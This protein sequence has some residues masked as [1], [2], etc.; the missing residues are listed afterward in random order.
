MNKPSRFILLAQA[1]CL[2]AAL[3]ACGAAEEPRPTQAAPAIQWR[4]ETPAPLP[5]PTI[6]AEL[7]DGSERGYTEID[8]DTSD[9]Y[10]DFVFEQ[11]IADG[12]GEATF[13]RLINGEYR[14]LGSLPGY[15]TDSLGTPSVTLDGMGH[16]YLNAPSVHLGWA[17]IDRAYVVE[18][19]ALAE[20]PPLFQLYYPI[21]ETEFTV[22][23]PAPVL[24]LGRPAGELKALM[25]DAFS[26]FDWETIGGEGFGGNMRIDPGE[27]VTVFG[28][29][30]R[31]NVLLEYTHE[32]YLFPMM[33]EEDDPVWGDL[34]ADGR[35][36]NEY[37]YN[38][39]VEDYFHRG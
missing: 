17:R 27:T 6:Q 36:F 11:R 12:Y 37:F 30:E 20:I 26:P 8:I 1:A 29:D 38:R 31:G 9:E 35:F 19:G 16:L 32:V 13:F 34:A 28:T 24:P 4:L 33:T 25:P 23:L 7:G 14:E 15:V 2:L 39:L 3:T 22:R 18:N 10:R 21:E 5:A